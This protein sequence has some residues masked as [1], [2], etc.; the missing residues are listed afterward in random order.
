M[1]NYRIISHNLAAIFGLGLAIVLISTACNKNKIN[2]DCKDVACTEEFRSI[3][4]QVIGSVN[5]S[6]TVRVKNA[7]GIIIKSK[8]EAGPFAQYNILDDD[9]MDIL[10]KI[11]SAEPFT[12]EVLNDNAVVG[13]KIFHIGKDCCHIFKVE[14]DNVIT[15]P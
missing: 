6:T 2:N 10:K 7:A 1:K 9:N 13:S 4:V 15:I 5:S 8:I 14:A 12:V 3:I 11:N